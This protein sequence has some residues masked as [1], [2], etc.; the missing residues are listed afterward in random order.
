MH[1]TLSSQLALQTVQDAFPTRNWV[2]AAEVRDKLAPR[3]T[4]VGV[5]A[6]LGRAGLMRTQVRVGRA[7]PR[8]WL[9]R[10]DYRDFTPSDI[11]R[12]LLAQEP[13]TPSPR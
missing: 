8:V 6:Q 11:R 5:G 12:E 7:L 1:I 4:L 3:D 9:L 2:T 13:H 10:G